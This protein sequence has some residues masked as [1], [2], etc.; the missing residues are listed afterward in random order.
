MHSSLFHQHSHT[1]MKNDMNVFESVEQVNGW[2]KIKHA[3]RAPSSP[4][5]FE[6]LISRTGAYMYGRQDTIEL[7]GCS[8]QIR[9]GQWALLPAWSAGCIRTRLLEIGCV[10][11]LKST[12]SFRSC[13][14]TNHNICYPAHWHQDGFITTANQSTN[15]APIRERAGAGQEKTGGS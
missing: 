10:S 3:W 6:G 13:V 1:F 15:R 9:S 8:S 12:T 7:I 14:K 11:S 2:R 5:L 4:W